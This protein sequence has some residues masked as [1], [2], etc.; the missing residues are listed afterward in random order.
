MRLFVSLLI[1]SLTLGSLFA[2]DSHALATILNRDSMRDV[3]LTFSSGNDDEA[4][5]MMAEMAREDS[6]FPPP[7]VLLAALHLTK[8]ERTQ[9]N[10]FC[11]RAIQENPNDPQPWLMLAEMALAE[12][13]LVEANLLLE[14]SVAALERFS[15]EPNRN[16]GSGSRYFSLWNSFLSTSAYL[17]QKQGDYSSAVQF[18][19]TLKENL[20]QEDGPCLTLGQ[21]YLQMEMYDDAIREFDEARALN[22]LNLPGWLIAAELLDRDNQTEKA[23]ELARNHFNETELVQSLNA[24]EVGEILGDWC[25]LLLKWNQLDEAEELLNKYS[26]GILQYHQLLGRLALLRED[27]QKAEKEYQS[28]QLRGA[29]DFDTLNGYALALCELDAA[30]LKRAAGLAKENLKRNPHL[31]EAIATLAWIELLQGNVDGAWERIHPLL[32]SGSFTP[33]TAYFIAEIAFALEEEDLCRTLLNLALEQNGA[34]P[35]RA[36][37]VRLKESL[38]AEESEIN[39]EEN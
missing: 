12:D 15:A 8:G 13:R 36:A 29:T 11:A 6:E 17:A 33:T 31:E 28:A 27:Y 4:Y 19:L 1:L 7:A 3:R 30:R 24:A 34:F 39:E 5:R 38:D 25:R 18:L 2:A 35:K 32:D 21:L 14:K 37:A 23:K 10:Q 22:R 9:Y 20:P 26:S 16:T